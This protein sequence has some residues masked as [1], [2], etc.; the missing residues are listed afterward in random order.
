M[1]INLNKIKSYFKNVYYAILN[2]PNVQYTKQ[3]VTQPLNVSQLN[4]LEKLFKQPLYT[5]GMTL[6]EMAY[7]TGKYDVVEFIK[8]W[9]ARGGT[10]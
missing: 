1:K 10:V 5:E 9:S 2:K 4:H 7:L 6:T 8:A 3:T